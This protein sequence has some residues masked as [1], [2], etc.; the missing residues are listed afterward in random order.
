[1][2]KITK[3]IEQTSPSQNFEGHGIKNMVDVN[4]L[5]KFFHQVKL[6]SR[7][8]KALDIALSL[9]DQVKAFLGCSKVMLIPLD[10]F[11]GLLVT[12]KQI[13]SKEKL[14]FI[15]QLDVKDN[16]N[17]DTKSLAVVARSSIDVHDILFDSF[18]DRSDPIFKVK[19][20]RMGILFRQSTSKAGPFFILHVE[21][22][23]PVF[24][25]QASE[26]PTA[27]P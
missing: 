6:A 22:S 11:F 18:E 16:K 24:S 19:E 1:V 10:Y 17:G 5:T 26:A 9:V 12:S 8:E 23:L 3:S 25:A 13:N 4:K 21:Y 20:N 7:Q 15:H 27:T 14:Q 2:R